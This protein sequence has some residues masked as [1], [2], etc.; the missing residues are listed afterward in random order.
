[1]LGSRPCLDE[2]CA[3][4]DKLSVRLRLRNSFD[5][6]LS[7]RFSPSFLASSSA[8]LACC[9]HLLTSS[10]LDVPI[11]LVRYS[12]TSFLIVSCSDRMTLV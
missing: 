9:F 6:L 11:S 2:L 3:R 1:M 8:N 5:S 4:F 12:V 7:F 10:S